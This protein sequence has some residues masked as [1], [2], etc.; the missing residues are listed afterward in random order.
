MSADGNWKITMNTP[1][2]TRTMD[3]SIVTRGDAFAGKVDSEMGTQELTGKIDGNT[4]TWS[5]D[6]TNPM[7]MT[8]EFTVKVDGDKMTGNVKIG[9]F[10]NA[11]LTGE[12]A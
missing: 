11:V 2:G 10:G 4:L 5:T 6:I 9:M 8:L 1:M 3:V 7:P 12:R